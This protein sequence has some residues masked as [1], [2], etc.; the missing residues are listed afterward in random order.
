MWYRDDATTYQSLALAAAD[1]TSANDATPSG[2]T[3]M[4]SSATQYDSASITA[5]AGRNGDYVSTAVGV[6]FL[7]PETGAGT[8]ISMPNIVFTWDEA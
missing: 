2:F 1:N 7:Y 8:N 4:P 3:A 5:G 6:S